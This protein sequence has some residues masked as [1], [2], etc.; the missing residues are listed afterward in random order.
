[1]TLTGLPCINVG[2]SYNQGER[3]DQK[4]LEGTCF[5][6]PEF[7]EF[8]PDQPLGKAIPSGHVSAMID[9]ARKDPSAN[10]TYLLE[11]GLP[12]MGI[13]GASR[14]VTRMLATTAE[15]DHSRQQEASSLHDSAGLVRV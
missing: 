10:L 9:F 15:Q 8:M 13:A 12:A 5:I 1:M 4:R 11:E 7:L 6:P 14:D 2:V 3:N